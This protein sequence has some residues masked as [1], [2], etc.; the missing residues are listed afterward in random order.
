MKHMTAM[1]THMANI[2]ALLWELVALQKAKWPARWA[3]HGDSQ[4][5]PATGLPDLRRRGP[6]CPGL[7]VP[8]NIAFP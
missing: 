8:P 2:K 3:A 5:P 1:E 4:S 7:F 6:P